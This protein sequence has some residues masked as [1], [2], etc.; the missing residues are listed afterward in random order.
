[1]NYVWIV[2]GL[3]AFFL[4]IW[5]IS[6]V[7]RLARLRNVT[8]E[9][10]AQVDVALKRRYDLIPNLIEACKAYAAHEKDLFER[11]AR[12]RQRARDAQSQVFEE[13]E[14]VFSVNELLA[15]AEGYPPLQSSQPFV[16]LLRELRNTEDRIAAARRFYNS[17]VRDFNTAIAQFPTSLF[18]FDEK[19]MPFYEIESVV[20]RDA[21]NVSL[22]R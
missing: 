1:M 6:V 13:N 16:Q 4:I 10:W 11:V 15:T 18:A 20:V 3:I 5:V 22:K 2:L 12:A 17:N 14:L 19:P 7:N 21:P 8:R 9:S